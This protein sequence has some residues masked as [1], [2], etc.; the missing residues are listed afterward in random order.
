VSRLVE[1]RP[2]NVIISAL[3][4]P[5]RKVTELVPLPEHPAQVKVPE[6]EKVTGSALASEVPN[7]T[8]AA[9]MTPIMDALKSLAILGPLFPKVDH[10]HYGHKRPKSLGLWHPVVVLVFSTS[11]GNKEVESPRV[12]INANG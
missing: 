8:M 10:P 12:K 6:V 11:L 5:P 3:P 2:V 4:M 9:S 7:A 1:P